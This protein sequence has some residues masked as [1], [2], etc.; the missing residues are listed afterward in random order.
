MRMKLRGA[1]ILGALLAVFAVPGKAEAGYSYC[2]EYTETVHIGGRMAQA[3]GTAC[4]NPDGTWQIVT[5]SNNGIF[6]PGTFALGAVARPPVVIRQPVYY[7]HPVSTGF[8]F[9]SG[10][11]RRTVHHHHHVHHTHRAQPPR[12]TSGRNHDRRGRDS[13][14]DRDRRSRR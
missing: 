3:Y 11:P 4:M 1:L 14:R 10:P 12:H 9:Y 2:R 7:H 6:V 8:F 5:R 13:N